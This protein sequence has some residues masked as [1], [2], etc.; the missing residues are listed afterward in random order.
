M[1]PSYPMN[2]S[3]MKVGNLTWPYLDA[4]TAGPLLAASPPFVRQPLAQE[5]KPNIRMKREPREMGVVAG[6]V[7]FLLAAA[8]AIAPAAAQVTGILGSPSAT[9]TINGKQLPPPPSKFGG[10]IKESAKDSKPWWPPRVVPPKGAPNVLLIMT[11]DQG[12]GISGT[13]GGVIPTPSLD[14]IA[15][16]GLR[17]TNF[18]S[19]ILPNVNSAAIGALSRRT[20]PQKRD[21]G[22]YT[23][24][25][26]H[27]PDSRPIG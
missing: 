6:V 15:N 1:L 23:A 13:F 27:G 5:K 9:T 8:L 21:H 20:G 22:T 10:V 19:T 18:N 3:R 14:R 11:D 2:G 4:P 24:R 16:S 17:Y 26:R 12:Y 25:S 7:A